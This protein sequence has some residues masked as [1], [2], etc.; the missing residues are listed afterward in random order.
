ML[1]NERNTEGGIPVIDESK[2]L[3]KLINFN[4]I[5]VNSG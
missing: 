2:L 4:R 5:M 1:K 3:E